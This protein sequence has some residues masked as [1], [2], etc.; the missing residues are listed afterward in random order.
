M[1]A[2]VAGGEGDSRLLYDRKIQL[3][4]VFPLCNATD[5]ALYCNRVGSFRQKNYSAED[6][7]GRTIGL[8]RRNSGCSAE[9]KTLGIP[10]RTIPW[11]V[12]EKTTRQD[13][14]RNRPPGSSAPH[15]KTR[16]SQI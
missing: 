8:F 5:K 10:F 16:Q 6:G 11:T 14:A 12:E 1:S 9:R 3:A 7:I 4:G 15:N 2:K 13:P